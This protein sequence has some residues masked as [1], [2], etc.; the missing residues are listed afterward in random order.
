MAVDFR[1][2]FSA[3]DG[4]QILRMDRI[5]FPAD[6]PPSI[7]AENPGVGWPAQSPSK[8]SPP[9]SGRRAAA[10]L[11]AINDPALGQ[12]VRGHFHVD[13]VADN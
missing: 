7:F 3:E 6:E 9:W 11:L 4:Q 10:D 12:V 2:A 13:P 8:T 1:P 5:C